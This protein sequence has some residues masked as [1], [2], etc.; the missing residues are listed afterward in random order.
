MCA[1]SKASAQETLARGVALVA[2]GSLQ[3]CSSRP[4][5]FPQYKDPAASENC[6]RGP[7]NEPKKKGTR[8]TACAS[9]VRKAKLQCTFPTT[10]SWLGVVVPGFPRKSVQTVCA[11]PAASTATPV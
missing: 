5:F 11:P 6:A 4:R 3:I 2:T 8:E 1:A 7:N 9:R 10:V